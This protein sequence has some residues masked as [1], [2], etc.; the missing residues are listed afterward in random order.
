VT[1]DSRVKLVLHEGLEVRDLY[2]IAAE[3]GL[4][5]RRLNFKRD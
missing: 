3:Q 1:G 5:I 2:R 4:Q